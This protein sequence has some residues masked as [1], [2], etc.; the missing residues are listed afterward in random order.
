M[1][2]VDRQADQWNRIEDPVAFFYKNDKQAEKEI[3]QTTPSTMVANNI[4][5]LGVTVTTQMKDLN[6]S[7]F[8]SL[9]KEMEEDLKK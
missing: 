9:K 2:L 5:Y 7:N 4:Q 3:S 1:V 6:D 8:K